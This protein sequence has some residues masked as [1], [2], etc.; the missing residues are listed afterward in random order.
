MSRDQLLNH[1]TRLLDQLEKEREERNFF[2]LERDQIYGFWKVAKEEVEDVRARLRWYL[3]MIPALNAR[4]LR[5]IFIFSLSSHRN[6]EKELDDAEEIRQ[7]D[8]SIYKQQIKCLLHEHQTTVAESR[9]WLDFFNKMDS[10][11]KHF[12]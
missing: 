7:K 4:R 2:Q 10:E 9:V 1:L 5:M 12:F 8:I 6:K 3:I 11:L